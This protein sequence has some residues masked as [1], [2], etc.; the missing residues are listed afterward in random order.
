MADDRLIIQAS[1]DAVLECLA[2]QTCQK[3]PGQK[4]CLE[5]QLQAGPGTPL[6]RNDSTT[7]I[8]HSN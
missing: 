8:K 2:V 7:S 5:L 1:S 3:L 6:P 4:S